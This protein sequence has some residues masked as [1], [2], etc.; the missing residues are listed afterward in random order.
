MRSL[1]SMLRFGVTARPQQGAGGPL[2]PLAERSIATAPDKP[3][4]YFLYSG[5]RLVFIGLAPRDGS[6]RR[7]LQRHL[8]SHDEALAFSCLAADGDPVPAYRKAMLRHVEA[9]DGRLP[10]WNL[11]A[12]QRQ[13]S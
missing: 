8:A 3:G 2:R 11:A 10:A 1:T 12:L 5:R 4:V 9:H 13:P 6:I 7:E